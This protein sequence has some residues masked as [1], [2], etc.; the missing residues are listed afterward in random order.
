[1]RT[2][3]V[4]FLLSLFALPLHAEKV[5][6]VTA[7]RNLSNNSDFVWLEIGIAESISQKLRNV[8]EYIVIDRTNI[9]KVM[10]E[11]Q[12]GQS[13]LIDEN[14]AK[15]AGKAMNADL[16]VVGNFQI[17]GKNV[18]IS[19]KIV[20]V[21]SHR[22]LR[23]VQTTG[24]ID[25]IF[26]LEDEIAL[27]IINESNI[28]LTREVKNRVTQNFTKN[29]SA[30]EFYS[31]AQTFY[32]QTRYTE[33]ISMFK[34]AITIDDKYSL[35]YA[36]LAKSYAGLY[37]QQKNYKN[38]IDPELLEESSENSRIAL[39]ISPRLDEAVLALAKYYQNVD[40]NRVKDKWKKCETYTRKAIDINQN[41]AEAWFLM[42]R[43]FGYN[44]TL[45]EKYLRK[46]LHLNSFMADANNNLGIIYLNQKKYDLAEKYF[47]KAIEVDPEYRTA[48]MNIGVV[49]SRQKKY[50][51]ALEMYKTIVEKYPNYLKGLNNLGIGYRHLEEYDKALIYFWKT[52]RIK[53]DY[54]PGWGE[55]AYIHLKRG[56]YDS[57]IKYYNK[58]LQYNPKH[59]Y[60]NVNIGIAY[61]NKGEYS[62][63]ILYLKRAAMYHSDYSFPAGRLAYIYQYKLDNRG[64]ALRWY[65]EALKR[66]PGNNYYRKQV[67][68]LS[69]Q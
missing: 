65:R 20:D 58:S 51:E 69:N 39:K 34:K 23:H 61:Q 52:V 22:V 4:L 5:I 32:F 30:Y 37:W 46:A 44:D 62:Q 43:I 33:A 36:G 12:L 24:I 53:P 26:S 57:A 48:Y 19:A 13:G 31:R 67:N 17:Y 11:I 28:E 7:F 15:Q 1:M 16:L 29:V 10:K 35:A 25:N 55:I 45:E 60:S 41:N 8:Q 14:S 49:Y 3:L 40:Q 27:K 42:S 63:A 6:G 47:R 50:Q 66:E 56:E 21:E 9:D 59:K 18:R 38:I 68:S 64:E 54:A 2:F